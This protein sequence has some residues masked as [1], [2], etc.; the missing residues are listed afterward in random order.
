[1]ITGQVNGFY[2]A[3]IPIRF[4]DAGGTIRELEAILDTAF[5]GTLRPYPQSLLPPCNCH[6]GHVGVPY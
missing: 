3:I 5:N 2:E 1:M 6:G 4:R